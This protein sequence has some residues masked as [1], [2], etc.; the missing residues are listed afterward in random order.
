MSFVSTIP[1]PDE[2]YRVFSPAAQAEVAG[3]V[4]R[5]ADGLAGRR[6]DTLGVDPAAVPLFAAEVEAT[7]ATIDSG[8][9]FVLYERIDGVTTILEQGVLAWVLGNLLGVPTVQNSEGWKV[10]EVY[11]RGVGTIEGG[12]RYHQTRQGAYVHNDATADP[13]P[14]DYLL[15]SCVRDAL[16]GGESILIDAATVHRKLLDHPDVLAVLEGD[17]WFENRGMAEDQ[18]LFRAPII[19]YDAVGKPLIK[20]FRVYMEA[21][22][23]KAGE[24]MTDEQVRALD[25]LDTL[26][27]QTPVQYRL[28]LEPGQSLV[29]ADERFLHTRTAFHDR[30]PARVV[31]P[32]TDRAEDVNRFMFRIWS[33]RA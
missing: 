10:I 30:F 17:F 29:Q 11:D 20:Y 9:H 32:A 18:R 19:G 21:A 22:H 3:Y 6:I 28:R 5:L 13:D 24:P 15:L 23:A 16:V 26:L 25:F 14:I 7:R 8:A 33:N 2:S 31:D 27:D 4:K 12:V 1:V